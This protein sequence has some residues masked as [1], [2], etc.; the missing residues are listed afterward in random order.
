MVEEVELYEVLHKSIEK[1]GIHLSDGKSEAWFTVVGPATEFLPK[2]SKGDMVECTIKEGKVFFIKATGKAAQQ[3][4]KEA[5]AFVSAA[6]LGE[7]PAFL[8]MCM[9]QAFELAL[10]E[11]NEQKLTMDGFWKLYESLVHGI[12]AVNRRIRKELEGN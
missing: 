9:N 1:N 5:D 11:K 12:V 7:H 8:G 6:G 10:K 2:I 4:K 3:P